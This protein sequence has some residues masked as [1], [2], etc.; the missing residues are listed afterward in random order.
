MKYSEFEKEVKELGFEIEKDNH[1]SLRV[2]DNSANVILRIYTDCAYQIDN[3]YDSFDTLTQK[4]KEDI[5]KLAIELASTPLEER[6]DEKCFYLQM[7]GLR[8][9]V[10][11][12]NY[13]KGTSEYSFDNNCETQSFKIVFNESDVEKMPET[14]RKAIECG[15][16]TK[17]EVK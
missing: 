10:S 1:S 13:A 9:N 16:I 2:V 5:F 7:R 17:I 8:E 15:A 6:E 12:V 14:I 4:D 3:A 11:Y